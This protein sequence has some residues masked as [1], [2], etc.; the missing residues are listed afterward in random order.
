[1]T[2]S[3]VSIPNWRDLGGPPTIDG[4]RLRPGSVFRSAAIDAPSQPDLAKLVDL[5]IGTVFDLRTASESRA[6]P[7]VA[8]A[9]CRILHADV[10]ADKHI[11]A[12]AKMMD[13]L[14]SPET[15]ES[16]LDGGKAA[17]L[18]IRNYRDMVTLPSALAAYRTMVR[19]LVDD[20][21]PA[22]V[23]CT[24]GKDRTGWA[25]AIVLLAIGADEQ[26]V[27][28]DYLRTNDLYLPTL[29][30][31]FDGYRESGGDPDDLRALLGVRSEYLEAA[32]DEARTVH[33][34]ISG[35]LEAVGI[36][37]DVC[38]R[39]RSRMLAPD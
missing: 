25:A 7:D 20:E 16:V 38:A 10:L 4:R 22:L 31:T 33:G 37:D 19:T 26:T 13:F 9:H 32:L 30:A 2:D 39:L 14:A 5:G 29:S 12:P 15:V 24:S 34:S 35:Y 8:P 21:R 3:P 27:L 28:T 23:H 36:D 18:M 17:E 11:S 6:A 1:M